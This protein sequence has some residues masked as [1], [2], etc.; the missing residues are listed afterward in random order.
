VPKIVSVHTRH[1]FRLSARMCVRASAPTCRSPPVSPHW[2][3]PSRR[4]SA[5][6]PRASVP[7]HRL[8]GAKALRGTCVTF[9]A[10]PR[11][12]AACSIRPLDQPC[13][14]FCD[15]ASGS[16]VRPVKVANCT[17]PPV[18]SRAEISQILNSPAARALAAPLSRASA[19]PCTC[20]LKEPSIVSLSLPSRRSF[21]SFR[22][23]R[24]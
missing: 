10:L 16:A 13:Q 5:S 23:F 8:S 18:A 17:V 6:A 3:V 1:P 11:S 24:F 12:C 22:S 2:S 21:R 15:T 9:H 4:I 14:Q 7:T 20:E 19:S